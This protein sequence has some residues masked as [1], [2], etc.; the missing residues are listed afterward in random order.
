MRLVSALMPT[1]NRRAFVPQAIRCF[2]AQTHV[3]AELVILDDGEEGVA[4]LIPHDDERV[5][6]VGLTTRAPVARKLAW[7]TKLAY[8]DVLCLWDDDDWHGPTRIE[9]QLEA[10]DDGDD[11]VLIERF[12]GHDMPCDRV[13]RWNWRTLGAFAD[14]TAMFTRAFYDA[15]PAFSELERHPG[16]HLMNS[17]PNAKIGWVEGA[18]LYVQ[19]LHG[20]NNATTHMRG[21]G[22]EPVDGELADLIRRR[23]RLD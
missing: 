18:E 23:T 22:W 17:R 8:G 7:L 11:A 4:D 3:D 12:Y 9:R 1:H 19:R 13:Y 10:I 5:R 15:G 20:Q 21:Y 14:G 16:Q 2:Q 6:Y